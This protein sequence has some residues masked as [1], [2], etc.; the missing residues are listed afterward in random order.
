MMFCWK[1]VAPFST[2]LPKLVIRLERPDQVRPV[3]SDME[4]EKNPK[5]L[6]HGAGEEANDEEKI[7]TANGQLGPLIVKC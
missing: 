4:D 6:H 2:S 7:Q 5:E 1:K 3:K